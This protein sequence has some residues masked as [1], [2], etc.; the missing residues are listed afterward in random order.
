DRRVERVQVGVQD[1]RFAAGHE[2]MFAR[3]DLRS[4]TWFRATW[5]RTAGLRAAGFGADRSCGQGRRRPAEVAAG[6]RS[7]TMP[8]PDGPGGLAP[9]L[10]GPGAPPVP[11]RDGAPGA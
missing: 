4:S 3:P 6:P 11:A 8:G 1:R 9:G 10:W 5:F 2:H 7:G